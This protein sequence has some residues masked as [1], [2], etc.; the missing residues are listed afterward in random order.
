MRDTITISI[1][2]EFKKQ[3]DEIV[4]KE[5]LSR[6]VIVRESLA[7]YLWEHRFR[8]IR[9]RMMKKAAKKGIFTDQDVFDRVS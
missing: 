4:Y 6:S 8:G 3:I 1:P 2:K 9:K 7:D 5:G